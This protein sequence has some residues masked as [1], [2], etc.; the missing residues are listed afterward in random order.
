[1]E[2]IFSRRRKIAEWSDGVKERNRGRMER[3]EDIFT[4]KIATHLVNHSTRERVQ[5][6]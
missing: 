2:D 5:H 4:R 1:M 3:E 6:C